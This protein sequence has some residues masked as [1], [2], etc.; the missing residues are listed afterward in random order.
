MAPV[1][2][3]EQQAAVPP[4]GDPGRIS[5]RPEH[6]APSEVVEDGPYRVPAGPAVILAEEA[7]LSSQQFQKG[8]PVRA[9]GPAGEKASHGLPA[10][11][12]CPVSPGEWVCTVKE[13]SCWF[14]TRFHRQALSMLDTLQKQ[15]LISYTLLGR[16]AM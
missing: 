9:L 1:F 5:F 14:R 16:G 7:V 3:S 2:V 13:L 4:E 10:G 6:C 15:H 8:V 11:L 12:C